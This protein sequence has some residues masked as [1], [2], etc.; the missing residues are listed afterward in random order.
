MMVIGLEGM[1]VLEVDG[2]E[3]PITEGT[4]MIVPANALHTGGARGETDA[5]FIE[6]F[7]P[8]RRDYAYLTKYQKEIFKNADGVSWFYN[9][10]EEQT[11]EKE[12]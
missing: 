2:H 5:K 12:A 4:A 11:F 1:L 8:V 9:A 6:I 3:Y 7:S 10:N